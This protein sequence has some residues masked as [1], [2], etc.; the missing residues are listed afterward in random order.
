MMMERIDL[1]QIEKEIQQLVWKFDVKIRL[2][3]TKSL[4]FQELV[5]FVSSWQIQILIIIFS[6]NGLLNTIPTFIIFPY[7]P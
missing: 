4:S 6:V 3:C 7:N 5:D 1:V 2:P